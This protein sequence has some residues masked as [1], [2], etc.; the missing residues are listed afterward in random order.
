[1]LGNC[2][3]GQGAWRELDLSLPT[4]SPAGVDPGKQE[5][6]AQGEPR[7]APGAVHQERRKPVP[8]QERN[9]GG[10]AASHAQFSLA[11]LCQS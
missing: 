4:G 1:M 5:S 6:S 10:A 7:L 3:S 2:M 11:A 9:V 8:P